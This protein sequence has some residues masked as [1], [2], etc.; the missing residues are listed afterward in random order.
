MILLVACD[1][2]STLPENSCLLKTGH[3]WNRWNF[4]KI[5]FRPRYSLFT[6]FDHVLLL[7]MGGRT[8]YLGQSE[9]ALP[10]FRNLGY[11]M[12]EHETLGV[13]VGWWWKLDPKEL[14]QDVLP[15]QFAEK[16]GV[17][18][19]F[20]VA[21]LRVL[22][23]KYVSLFFQG[24][25]GSRMSCFTWRVPGSVMD[26][27][28]VF[29]FNG[30]VDEKASLLC[31]DSFS[32][33]NGFKYLKVFQLVIDFFQVGELVTTSSILQKSSLNINN[34]SGCSTNCVNPLR[35]QES[36]RLVHGRDQWQSG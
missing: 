19:G 16:V 8:V 20:R 35:S 5:H 33:F 32:G 15:F 36:C 29:F 10:Y 11:K 21:T 22:D 14:N 24:C 2:P 23:L 18:D 4:L 28:C 17:L 13:T 31:E 25:Y 9:G 12:P 6:L 7:G 27:T 30:C 26:A 34:R 1:S 3:F